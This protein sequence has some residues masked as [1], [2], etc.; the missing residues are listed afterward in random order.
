MK[1]CKKCGS[2]V[3]NE[4]NFCQE[5]GGSI[6][7][8]KSDYTINANVKIAHT[9]ETTEKVIKGIGNSFYKAENTYTS[10]K[11][12]LNKLIKPIKIIIIIGIIFYAINVAAYYYYTNIYF[13]PQIR[14]QEINISS[15]KEEVRLIKGKPD[16]IDDNTWRYKLYRWVTNDYGERVKV[17]NGFLRITFNQGIVEEIISTEGKFNTVSKYMKLF[18]FFERGRFYEENE[19]YYLPYSKDFI[20]TSY[21]N[22]LGNLGEPSEILLSDSKLV[23]KLF[24]HDHKTVFFVKENTVLAQG[25]YKE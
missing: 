13:P 9:N 19:S 20:N 3:N 23:R 1:L 17:E 7:D 25:I 5:C 12:K 24:Y 2:K 8:K 6:S 10:T 18:Y 14:F 21:E 22:L 4:A 11:S 16:E 15:S